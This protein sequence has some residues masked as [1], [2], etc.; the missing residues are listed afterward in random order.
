MK[1]LFLNSY[2]AWQ[3]KAEISVITTSLN[4]LV[5]IA[6]RRKSRNLTQWKHVNT[7]DSEK[8]K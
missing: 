4:C 1:C 7:E 2:T 8:G 5:H 6:W 3:K